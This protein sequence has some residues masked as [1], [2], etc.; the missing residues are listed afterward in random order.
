MAKPITITYK[1][2]TYTL[3]FN[4]HTVSELEQKGFNLSEIQNKVATFL[5]M[6]FAGA[7]TMHHRFVKPD[8]IDDIYKHIPNKMA[9]LDRLSSLYAEPINALFDEPEESEVNAVWDMED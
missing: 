3:E 5:P 4:R 9:L 2:R 1:D 8:I 7:F 6:L